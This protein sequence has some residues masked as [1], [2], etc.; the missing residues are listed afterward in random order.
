MLARPEVATPRGDAFFSRVYH[1]YL[2]GF[3]PECVVMCRAVIESELAA[4]ISTDDCIQVLGARRQPNYDLCDRIAVARKQ[5][6]LSFEGAKAA[7][8]VRE[9]GNRVVHRDPG[10]VGLDDAKRAIYSSLQVICELDKT[11]RR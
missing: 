7:N 2:C 1:S 3:A 10:N 9:L 11:R 8:E 4:E 5:E 6:R